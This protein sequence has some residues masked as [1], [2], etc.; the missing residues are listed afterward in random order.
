M[1]V[2]C[3]LFCRA[4]V[5]T[6]FFRCRKVSG[7][8]VTPAMGKKFVANVVRPAVG[9]CDKVLYR[10]VVVHWGQAKETQRTVAR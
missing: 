2:R 9:A 5:D 7:A 4:Y 8:L 6:Y 3:P 10:H 1:S